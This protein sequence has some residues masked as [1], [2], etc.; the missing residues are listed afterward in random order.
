MTTAQELFD[1]VVTALAEQGGPATDANGSCWYRMNF[2]NGD[3][4]KCA[5]GHELLDEHYSSGLE[6][7][8]FRRIASAFSE[9]AQANVSLMI[10]L[11][12][13]HDGSMRGLQAFKE[14]LLDI[15]YLHKLDRDGHRETREVGVT[16]GR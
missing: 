16:C 10:R 11:Q 2:S 6:G 4:W 15:A 14:A 1:R 9:G 8:P 7:Q 5:A 12:A 13:A 3:C